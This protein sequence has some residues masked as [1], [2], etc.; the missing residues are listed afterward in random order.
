M[1]RADV[2]ASTGWMKDEIWLGEK[3]LVWCDGAPGFSSLQREWLGS[4]QV[5]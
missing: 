2:G 1:T 5:N 3:I 4:F